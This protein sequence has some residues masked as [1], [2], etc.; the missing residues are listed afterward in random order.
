MLELVNFCPGNMLGNMLHFVTQSDSE[1][2]CCL[3][4]GKNKGRL[5][6]QYCFGAYRSERGAQG[7]VSPRACEC[8]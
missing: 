4:K 3:D 6:R 5:G 8:C 1:T 2:S 7:S